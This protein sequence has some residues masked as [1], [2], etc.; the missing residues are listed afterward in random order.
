MMSN[1]PQI[2]P[3]LLE[4]AMSRLQLM[5]AKPEHPYYILAPD[6][7]ET[8]SG[9]AT[10]HYLC[11]I[12]NLSGREA[13]LCGCEVL[14]PDLRTPMLDTQTEQ[15]H[16]SAGKMPIAVYPEVT[17]GSPLR[18]PVSA[19]LLLNFEGFLTGKGMQPGADDLMFYSGAIIAADSGEPG[20]D[21]LNLPII[22][23]ALFCNPDPSQPRQGAY[24]YQN[25]HPLEQVDYSLLPEGIR[26]LSMATPLTLAEL[27]QV[28]KSADILYTYEWSMTC[29]MALLCGCPVIFM[30]GYGI[31]QKFLDTCFVG[32][33]TGFAMLDQPDAVDHAR[34]AVKGA[35]QRYV[36]VTAPFWRQLD[37]FIEKTQ[38]AARDKARAQHLAMNH[39]LQAR[40]PD[41]QQLALMIERLAAN[42]SPGFAVLVIDDGSRA[43]LLQRTL[44]SLAADTLLYSNLQV[45][46]VD[47][48]AAAQAINQLAAQS[49][50]DWLMMV[51]AGVEF[52]PAGLLM[53]ALDL[54][55]APADCLAL[56]AD[57][58]MRLNEGAQG[59]SLR[60]DLNL[61]LLLSCP[62]GLS[63]HWLLRRDMFVEL[64]GFDSSC[65]RAFE[66][67]YQLRLIE[68]RGL[69][70]IGH[71]S[72]PLLVCDAPSLVDCPDERAVI[73]R[74]LHARGYLQAHV[75]A[76]LPGHYRIDY[77]HA[78]QASVSI[79]ILLEG[80]LELFQRCLD[81][82]LA[83]TDYPHY[84]VLLLDPGCADGQTR[85]WLAGVE[86]LGG[87]Q[88]RVLRFASGQART[89]LYNEAARE[90]RG[91]FVLWLDPAA[92]ILGKGWL[93]QLLNHAQRPEVGAV[94]AKL[95]SA[96]GKIHHAGLVLGLCGP[97]GRAF[98]GS[99]HQDAGYLQRLLVD[100]NYAALSGECLML[101][102]ELF[103]EAGGFDQEPLL[104][105]WID[106]DLCLKLQ[107]AGYLNVWT[108][109]VQM[110]M[111]PQT[112]TPATVEE[113][114]ALYARW[115]PVL[116]S[117][118]A[119]NANLS[120]QHQGGFVPVEPA[121]SWRPLHSWRP[122]PVVLAHN[123]DLQ[124]SGQQRVI[125][126]FAAMK[127]AGLIDG[128]LSGNLLQVAD[129]QR[130]APD[131]IV[132]QRPL[133]AQSLQAMRR[134]Q[135]FSSAFK[136]FE[137]DAYLPELPAQSAL[138][139]QM[140]EDLF[141]SLQRGLGYAD[142]LVVSTPVL[143]EVFAGL[144]DDIR[145]VENR[146]PSAWWRD[147]Q[148]QRR[149]GAKPR[150]GWA[151]GVE[152]VEEL[153]LISEL[154]KELAA[155]VD[156]VF[157]GSCPAALRPFVHEFHVDVP[158]AR[159]PAKLASL[160]LDLALAPMPQGLYNECKS[161]LRLLE[162][163]A[164]G[165]PVIAS[166][167]RCYQGCND[168]PVTLVS[169]TL[170]DWLQAI[171][172]HLA[173]RDAAQRLGAELRAAVHH[174]WMLEGEH[175]QHWRNAWLPG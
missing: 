60:S 35:F 47:A 156:W 94:G 68:E 166:D 50:A 129:L 145:I 127:A 86:Q 124:G 40:Y 108:P 24:L 32:S 73:E 160:D 1:A 107:Q 126:P 52:T 13:Y 167:V 172:M 21:V 5:F 33:G 65:G 27:A 54:L 139:R 34:L 11:H 48:H 169:N 82:L 101:R 42:P 114:D 62:A 29:V 173:D 63:K 158:L 89:V 143:A 148:G 106:V 26:L 93:E 146:L 98:E 83:N 116:A 123:A 119:Y 61:D 111:A 97:V 85:Q 31:D 132:L 115:L 66:L 175:L 144:H 77:G 7:R 37:V 104:M 130:Y 23:V 137:L 71:V 19:R 112:T 92:G 55:G 162:Y 161:N 151:G 157:L 44:A 49:S 76:H 118:P 155:H 6:Y 70:C 25:R 136:V 163:G 28:L 95:L 17:I 72:E 100:Q 110:L 20:G 43:E 120:L 8:S 51:E 79:V 141:A 56:Y 75:A 45:E 109:H 142:R 64:G 122:L 80:S 154:V 14:N 46:V 10:L 78:Q 149:M 170:Q 159:Y 168:L 128:A 102:R 84:E 38:A 18:C 164:C 69:A 131:T 22:D 53:V 15:R 87:E 58:A 36:E 134:M 57:E 12:L 171:R 99:A 133:D 16:R 174:G 117:D 140:P 74:H 3:R 96:E 39:W 147:L 59:V 152:R 138:R 4:Q 165:F 91:D 9:V 121:L 2:D 90:A 30:P 105:R 113:E 150:V 88:L 153:E 103:L 41:P 125:Q 135:A 81:A 67:H